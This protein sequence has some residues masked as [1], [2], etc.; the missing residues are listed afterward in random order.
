M[1][2][3]KKNKTKKTEGTKLSLPR[4]EWIFMFSQIL[5]SQGWTLRS[6]HFRVVHSSWWTAFSFTDILWEPSVS[7]WYIPV[8]E[9]PSVLQT[10]FEN[11]QFQSGT[12]QLT[13]S[14]QFHRHTLITFSFKVAH[15]S[16]RTAFS[17]TDI[18]WE[19]SV[20]KW[21]IPV[22][23]QPSVSQIENLQLQSGTFHLTNNLQFQWQTV[24]IHGH[25]L[26]TLNFKVAHSCWKINLIFKRSKFT[27]AVSKK[28]VLT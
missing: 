17:F 16:W 25:T 26:R 2:G 3:E 10:N 12:F 15:S 7:K 23:E 18:L 27:Q 11:L 19:P 1:H 20:S 8:D 22:D 13:N 5:H 24:I 6:F 4:T 14:L 21:H 9:Q 28:F